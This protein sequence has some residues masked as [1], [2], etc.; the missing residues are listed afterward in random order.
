MVDLDITQNNLSNQQI[1]QDSETN[2]FSAK[3]AY[4]AQNIASIK[5][6]LSDAGYSDATLLAMTKND[7]IYAYRLVPEEDLPDV[8]ELLEGA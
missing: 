1:T 4:H 2:S 7:L 6:I 5:A 8:G 3:R